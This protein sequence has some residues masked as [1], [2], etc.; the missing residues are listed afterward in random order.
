MLSAFIFGIP[1]QQQHNSPRCKA[2]KSRI[3]QQWV[4]QTHWSWNSENHQIREPLWHQWHPRVHGS[5]GHVPAATYDRSWLLRHGSDR[6]WAYAWVPALQ[7][8]HSKRHKGV[9]T[10]ETGLNK[11]GGYSDW[12][13]HGI[14][15]FYQ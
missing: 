11:K 15:W 4:R 3:R 7:R 14:R 2:R 12:V 9:D 1:P 13:E 6:L 5:W 10:N 8:P